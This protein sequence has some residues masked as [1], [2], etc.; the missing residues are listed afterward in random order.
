MTLPVRVRGREANGAVWDEVSRCLDVC[1]GGLGMLVSHPVE[2]GQILH[3][4]TPLPSRL[5][6]YDLTDSS[7]RVYALVRSTHRSASG[8]RVGVMFL[9]RH[10]PRASGP[11]PRGQ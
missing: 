8:S 6:Q 2:A 1:L 7:Y 3:L 9:G 10:P 11:L 5:R 4:S